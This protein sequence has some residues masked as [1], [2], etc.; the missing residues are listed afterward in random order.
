MQFIDSHCHL[1]RINLEKEKIE[2]GQLFKNAQQNQ[3]CHMLCVAISLD[4][5][6]EMVAKARDY[7]SVSFSCGVHPLHV[8]EDQN[9]SLADLKQ[10]ASDNRVVAIGETG[11]DY[12]YSKDSIKLQ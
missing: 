10:L 3:V 8:G 1:D 12:Y 7:D 6:P 5:Y 2:F 9:Y 11:L 4:Q